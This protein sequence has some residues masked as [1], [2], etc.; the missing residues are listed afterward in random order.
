MGANQEPVEDFRSQFIQHRVDVENYWV[1]RFREDTNRFLTEVNIHLDKNNIGL[2]IEFIDTTPDLGIYLPEG[3]ISVTDQL[4]TMFRNYSERELPPEQMSG[5]LTREALKSNPQLAREIGGLIGLQLQEHGMIQR[6][7]A[8]DISFFGK[9]NVVYEEDL[10]AL[11]ATTS[12]RLPDTESL[13][14]M[15][16]L[17]WWHTHPE[18]SHASEKDI[19]SML[20]TYQYVKREMS[21]MV[22]IPEMLWAIYIPEIDK[23][24][25]Y[26]VSPIK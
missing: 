21:E 25:W 9:N 1:T 19:N 5:T 15:D 23:I 4:H 17:V 16:K 22:S 13:E 6:T 11:R 7:A 20:R 2:R 24:T 26:K 10:N 8:I 12:A 14:Y 3:G 18:I